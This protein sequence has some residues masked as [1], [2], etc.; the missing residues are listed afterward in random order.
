MS[1]ETDA[2]TARVVRFY[3]QLKPDSLAHI[4]TVYSEQ[5]T[6]KDPFNDVK[7]L[8]AITRVFQHMFDTL[9]EPRFVVLHTMTQ[10]DQAWLTWNFI[11]RRA[12]GDWTIHGATHLRFAEDGRIKQHRDYWDPAQE[13]YA[14]L[15]ILGPCV[16]WLTR[17]LSASA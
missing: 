15:P 10:G 13:L 5:A 2:R 14:R 9:D 1:L 11:I 12:Q 8:S 3:E 4:H 6:F 17:R 7:G 16:R